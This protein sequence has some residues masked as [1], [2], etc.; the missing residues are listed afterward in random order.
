M[1]FLFIGFPVRGNDK[2]VKNNVRAI[3]IFFIQTILKNPYSSVFTTP[4]NNLD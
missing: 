3:A 4:K 2:R 1:F